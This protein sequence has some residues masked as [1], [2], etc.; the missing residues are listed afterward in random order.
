MEKNDYKLR[1]KHTGRNDACPCGS[2]K[3]YKKCHLEE[4]EASE[5]VELAVAVSER[6]T[7]LAET[8]PDK[9]DGDK[10]D[11]WRNDRRRVDR[12]RSGSDAHP[13]IPRR[14]AI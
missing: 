13:N 2:G 4:D 12:A 14:G 1:L 6:E 3:K 11:K 8:D 5:R 7:A 9:K 10:A